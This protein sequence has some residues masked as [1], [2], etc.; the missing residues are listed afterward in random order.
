MAGG[1]NGSRAGHNVRTNGT[2]RRKA[3]SLLAA[4]TA[5]ASNL[6]PIRA[7]T[8][9]WDSNTGTAG[10]Q[11]GGGNW[12]V[13]STTFWNGTTNV[14]TLNDLTSDIAR[15]GNGGTLTA[16]DN[17][18]VGTQS[19]NG[20]VFDTTQS[21]G[22]TLLGTTSGQ[23]LS[24]GSGGITVNSGALATTVGNAT[25]LDLNLGA[26]QTWTNNSTAGG[27]TLTVASAVRGLN[28]NLTLTGSANT[29]VSGVIS[30]GGNLIKDGAGTLTLVANNTYAGT[31]TISAG[32]LAINGGSILPVRSAV[33]VASGATFDYRDTAT[34]IGSLS[35]AGTVTNSTATAGRTLTIGRDDTSTTF[36]GQFLG[37]ATKSRLAI[38]KIGAGT[39]TLAPQSGSSGTAAG[40]YT[41]A[42]VLNGGALELDFSQG[43]FTGTSMLAATAPTIAGGNLLVKGRSGESINQTLGNLTIGAGGGSV[44]IN[45]NAGTATRLNFGTITS[46][47][48]GGSLLVNSPS[49]ADVR[50]NQALNTAINGRIVFTD[51]TGT[52]NWATNAGVNTTTVGLAAYTDVAGGAPTGTDTNNSRIASLI[53]SESTTLGGAWTTNS[54]RINAGAAGQSL[55]LGANTLTLTNGG[56]LF[57]GAENYS[58]TATTGTLKSNTATNSDLV[59]HNYGS[60]NLTIGAIIAN[61]AGASTLTTAGT[62]VVTLTGVNTF[63]GAVFVGGNS[64]LSFSNNNQLGAATASTAINIRDGATL[65]YTGATA[66][67]S[68]TGAASHSFV[69]QGGNANFEVVSGVTLTLNGVI[70]GAGGFTK[71]G[72]GGL[73]LTPLDGAGAATSHTYTGPTF[74]S[75]GTLTVGGGDRL[76]DSSPV[77]VASLATYNMSAGSDT[78]GS[79]AGAGIVSAGTTART[80]TMGG[81]NTSTTFTGTLT[82]A[83]GHA[84]TKT[85]AGTMTVGLGAVTTWTGNTNVNA[86]ILRLTNANVPT[87][88]TMVIGNSAAPAQLDLNGQSPTLSALTFL[89]T[90]S[91]PSSEA[92]IVG[93]SGTVTLNGTVTY[94]AIGSGGITALRPAT[95]SGSGSLAMTAARTFDIR[96]S[97]VVLP[98]EAELT[99]GSGLSGAGGGITKTGGGNLRITGTN[100]MSGTTTNTFNSGVTW[101]DYSINNTAKI[102]PAANLAL[103]GGTLTLVGNSSNATS[104]SVA[105]LALSTG[106]SMIGLDSGTGQELLL[107]LG[108]AITRTASQGL[109]RFNLP[110]GTQAGT[111]GFVTSQ[112][113]AATGI[114]GGF[115]TVTDAS[116]ITGFAT[117]SGT[118]I[119]GLASTAQDNVA[120]WTTGIHATDN[121]G[122]TGTTDFE[123]SV[124]SLRFNASAGASTV[125]VQPG[126]LLRVESG[127][128]LQTANVTGGVSV[129]SG[130][131]LASA[132]GNELMFTTDSAS[133]RLEV[134]STI[135]GATTI[136]KGGT[137]TL[138]INSSSNSFTGAVNVFSG[139]LQVS[140]GN[141]IGDT[142][143]LNLSAN[144]GN[145]FEVLADETVGAL[146]SMTT[147]T[148]SGFTVEIRLTSGTLTLNQA[149]VT[150]RTFS[151]LITGAGGFV[152]NGNSGGHNLLLNSAQSSA[153]TGS[154]TVN[155]GLFYVESAGTLGN[156]S[157]LRL[158]KGASFLIS[159]NSTTSSNARILDTT[160][161][162]LNSADG[163]W[164]TETRPSGL[165]IRRDQGS[166]LS[167]TIGVLSAESGASYARLEATVA[168]AI[169]KIQALN[170]TRANNATFAVRGTN[171]SA[172][173]NQR[174]G[175]VITD[176]TNQTAF[177]ASMVGGGSTTLGTK[178]ISIIPWMIAEETT[179]GVGDANMGNTLATYASGQSVRGLNLTTEYNTFASKATNQDNIRESLAANLT[180]VVGQTINSLVINNSS[181]T[182]LSLNVTGTGS[183]QT[184]ALTS[185]TMLFTSTAAVT[186]T[187][188]MA[189]DLGGFDAGIS[190]GGSEYVIFVQN[191]TSAAASGLLTATL[192]SPL[193]STADLTKAG[194]GSLVLTAGGAAGGGSRKTTINEGALQIDALDKIGGNTGDL[195][196]AGGTLR[197]GGVFD[198]STRT[199]RFLQAGGTFDTQTNNIELANPIGDSTSGT[200]TK[201]GSGTLTFSAAATYTGGTIISAGRVALNGGVNGMGTG[202]TSLS[203]AT[204]V[205]Q[206]GGGAGAASQTVTS[207]TGIAGSSIVG[208][209]AGVSTLTVNQSSSTSYLGLIGGAGA[210]E[211]NVAVVKSGN[212]VLALGAVANTFTGG[213][214]VKAG[215]VVGGNNANTFGGNTNVITIGDTS[216]TADASVVFINSQSYAQPITVASGSSGAAT[217]V[218]GT[219][220]GNP[221][222]TGPISLNK[223]LVLAKD[224]TTG[225]FTIAGGIGGSGN[226]FISNNATTGTVVLSTTAIN[227]AGSITNGG[228]ASGTTTISADIGANVNG[229]T[230]K[231]GTSAL[232]LSAANIAFN[233]PITVS[234][235]TLNITGAGT[236]APTVTGLTVAG[237]ATLNTINTKGQTVNLGAGTLNLGAGAGTATFGL[238]LGSLSEYDSYVTSGTATTA[239]VV[240][241]NLTTISGFG[242]GTYTLFQA[243]GGLS[244]ATYTFTASGLPSGLSYSLNTSATQVQFA[245]T[246]FVSGSSL[247]WRGAVNNSWA[248]LNGSLESNF[249]TDAAGTTNAMGLPSAGQSV[250]F[251][252]TGVSGTS[253]TTTLDSAVSIRDLTFNN[254][255]G[256][257]PLGTITVAAGS[258]GTLTLTPTASTAGIVVETGAPAA[259]NI[260]APVTLG[261]SQTWT[262]ADATTVLSVSGGIGG[263][264]G[265]SLT[266]AGSGILALTGTNNYTGSTTVAGGVLRAGAANTLAAG[267]AHVVNSTGT[268]RLNGFANTIP[269]LA[270]TSGGIV[271]NSSGT[272]AILTVSGSASTTFAGTVQN[273][274]GAGTLELRKA[275]GHLTLSGTNTFTGQL[276]VTSVGGEAGR[277]TISGATGTTTTPFVIGSLAGGRGILNIAS[278]A[279]VN[280]SD[281]DMGTNTSAGATYLSGGSL[282]LAAGDATDVFTLG[283]VANSYGYF[284]QSGGTLVANRITIGGNAGTSTGVY[285]MTGG[286]ATI[287]NWVIVAHGVNSNGLLD[288]AGGTLTWNGASGFATSVGDVA[289]QTGVINIRGGGEV[290]AAGTTQAIRIFRGNNA[291]S[292]NS[293]NILNLMSGG[294]LRT[295]SQGITNGTASGAT[296]N[297][298][299]INLNGGTIV[300]N[301]ATTGLINVNNTNS[302]LTSTSGAFM[303]SGGLTVDTNSFN[304]TLPASLLAPSGVGV[305]SIAV[306]TAGEG[307]V[308]APMVKISGG[309]GVGATAVANMIDDGL[310][311]GTLK[312]GSITITNPGTGYLATDVLT[313][314]LA[315]NAQTY[316]TQATIGTVTMGSSTL[317]SGGLTK[318]G[319]GTLTLSSA[320]SSFNGPV[321]INGGA[322]SAATFGNIGSNGPLGTGV[323]TNDATN[324][325]SIVLAGGTLS[326]AGTAATATDRLFTVAPAGGQIDS[327]SGTAAN[328]VTFGNTGAIVYSG[329]GARTLT[330]GGANTGANTFTPVINDVS[331]T[332]A[333]SVNKAGAGTW[334]LVGS[335]GYTGGTNIGGGVLIQNGGNTLGPSG[336]ITFTA[337]STLRWATGV[338]NDLSGRLVLAN[339][340]TGTID[341]NGNNVVFAT[342][343]GTTGGTTGVL[344]KAGAGNLTLNAAATHTGG[345]TLTTGGLNIGHAGA[346]GIGTLTLATAG[347]TLDNTSG[348]PLTIST[349]PAQAW[350]N[351]FTFVGTNDLNLGTGAVTLSAARTVT[352]NSNSLTV[353]GVIDGLFAVNKA[354][355]GTLYL[356][357]VNT[358]GAAAGSAL[359]ISGGVLKVDDEAGL[360]NALNDITFSAAGTLQVTNGFNANAGKVITVTGAPGTIQVDAGTLTINSNIVGSNAAGGG[361]IKTGAGTLALTAA[362]T[363]YDAQGVGVNTATG[364]GFRVDAGTLLLQSSSNSVVGDNN[365]NNMTVQLNGGHLGIQTDVVSIARANVWVS[366]PATITVNNDSAGPGILQAIG[367]TGGSQ[368][369][370]GAGSST[371]AIVGGSNVTSGTAI[372]QFANATFVVAPTITITNPAAATMQLSLGAVSAAGNTATFEGNGNLVQS[373]AWS[374]TGGAGI[375]FGTSFTGVATLSQANTYPGV[376]TV[377]GG[378]LRFAASNNLGDASLTNTVTLGGGTLQYTASGTTDLTT[379]R[380]VS[381]TTGTTSTIEVT[382]STGILQASGGIVPSGVGAANLNKTGLGT[383]QVTGAINLN[384]GNLTVSGGTLQAGLAASG[385]GAVSVAGGA[386]LNLFDGAANTATISSLSLSSGSS[387]GF[388]LGAPG[389]PNPTVDIGT[390]DR[391][392]VSN[393]PTTTSPVSLNFNN[394]GGLGVGIYDLINVNSGTLTASHFVLGS[395][396]SGLNYT[397]TAENS[398]QTLRL[399]TT[400]LTFVH[401]QGD[402]DGSWSTGI[403]PPPVTATNWASD[404]AGTTDNLA[405][406]GSN[407]TVVFSTSNAVLT[408]GSLTTTLDGNFNIDSLQFVALPT[409][410]A[411]T[412]VTSVTV[413]QGTSGILTVAPSSSNNGILVGADAGA[414][415]IN[416][417]LVAGVNQ[418]W[419]VSGTGASLTIGDVTYTGSVTKT[420]P[421]VLTLAGPGSGTGGFTLA[422]GTLNVGSATALGTGS[423]TIE[424]GTTIANS[425]ASALT[426]TTNNAQTWNGS[427]TFGGT[428]N[429]SLGTGAVTLAQSTT[430]TTSTA[431]LTIGGAISDGGA[432]RSLTKA[433]TGTLTVGGNA[434]IGGNLAV[435]GGTATF[436]GA[437]NNVG[438]SVTASGTAF[439]MNGNTTVGNGISVTAGTANMAGANNVTGSVVVTGGSLVFGSAANAGT[440]SAGV[441]VTGGSLTL[442]GSNVVGTGVTVNGGGTLNIGHA[443][444]LGNNIANT[445]TINGGTIDNTSGAALTLSPANRAHNWNG[446]FTFTGT[447]DLNLGTG[448]VDLGTSVTITTTTAGKSLTVGGVIDDG[449]GTLN[450]TKS[451]AGTLVLN[452]LN[453]YGG[454]TVLDNGTLNINS[455]VSLAGGVTFGSANTVTTAATLNLP[456]GATF[457]GPLIVQATTSGES[458]IALGA[459]QTLTMTTSA[460]SNI[461]NGGSAGSATSGGRLK[462]TGATSSLV[463]NAPGRVFRVG[464]SSTAVGSNYLDLSELG[465]LNMDLGSAGAFRFGS[466]ETANNPADTNVVKLA[467]NSTVKTGTLDI[468]G[469][470]SHTGTA[471][472][473]L[474]TGTTT[475]NANTI[476]I[477]SRASGNEARRASGTLNFAHATNGNVII[478]GYDGVAAA[479]INLVNSNANTGT[480]ISANLSLA[481]HNADVLFSTLTAASRTPAATTTTQN[482]SASITF[483]QGLFT[484]TG[485]T[486]LSNRGGASYT[487]GDTIASASFGGGSTSFATLTM[488][489]NSASTANSSGAAVSTLTFNGNGV[490]TIA[491]LNMGTSTVSGASAIDDP[492]FL[493]TTRATLD[494]SGTASLTITTL[495]MSVNSATS[496]VTGATSTKADVNISGGSVNVTGNVSMGNTTANPLNVVNNAITL[497][498]GTFTV[499]GNIA[500]TNGVG[501]ENA[502]ITLNNGTLDMTAGTIGAA[503]PATIVFNAQ[504]GTLQNLAQLNGGGTLTKSTAGT[505]ILTGTNAYTGVTD[506]TAGV[507]RVQSVSGLGATAGATSITAG[508]NLQI[509]NVDIGAENLTLNGTG[510][511]SGGALTGTGTLAAVGGGVTLAS[512][513][514]VGVALASDTLTLSGVID[515]TGG[516]RMLTKV[517]AGRL[518]LSGSSANTFTGDLNIMAG[519]V[520]LNKTAGVIAIAGD[521]VDSKSNPDVLINGGTLRLL[522]DNQIGDNVYIN[523]TSGTFSLNGKNETIFFFNN[524]GGAFNSGRGG[525]LTVTD[526][527]WS[528]GTNHV[529]NTQNYGLTVPG[530]TIEVA[531]DISGGLNMVHGAESFASGGVINVGSDFAIIQFSGATPNLTLNGDKVIP[532]RLSL[533]GNVNVTAGTQ[534]TITSGQALLPDMNL[535]DGVDITP[536][537]DQTGVLAGKVD[538][539]TGNRT[540]TVG[541]G[542]SLAISAVVQGSGGGLVKAGPGLMTLSAINTYTGPTTITAGTLVVT[543][544]ISSATEAVTNGTLAGNGAVTEAVMVNAGGTIRPGVPGGPATGVLTVKSL[545][546]A[547]NTSAVYGVDITGASPGSGYDQIALPNAGTSTVSIDGA[548]LSV[549]LGTLLAGDG[550]EKFYIINNASPTAGTVTG[551]FANLIVE[552]SPA[553]G[554]PSTTTLTSATPNGS[555]GF[556]FTDLSTGFVYTLVYNVD[557]LT[558]NLTPGSG[559]DVVLSVVPE[560]GSLALAA[561]AGLGL[562]ARRRRK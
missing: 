113:N 68:Q 537:P 133:Q 313:V 42:T 517:G 34:T 279:T 448:A 184:L 5:I 289:G 112:A 388:D 58:I 429:L 326:Y 98:T 339:G 152:V 514:S 505:L 222:L 258:G 421:G 464:G 123:T 38:T 274:T 556:A 234:G 396:P 224:G 54:L 150:G 262:V 369:T 82:G 267:S 482:G 540:F 159:N 409:S 167:E 209:N 67:I 385:V 321:T 105:N 445:F 142:A 332:E 32:T 69:L 299:L 95:I 424:A 473:T 35:G 249:T 94:N 154:V 404:A 124:N 76:P 74:I 474:N 426:L 550:S 103:G 533:F 245:A 285:R 379:N 127:G 204:S 149:S 215:T 238:E 524:S 449:V 158:N 44:I 186:G 52:F 20:L 147:S 173:A 323:A 506:V 287:N 2:R 450:L 401:W 343:V 479:A 374:G 90:G 77:T 31:T 164:N 377:N 143:A 453:T 538:L 317:A 228:L 50:F 121:S 460:D 433:G 203:G 423:L 37:P 496:A 9:D 425:T 413:N 308:G 111:N 125:T 508:A 478:R 359:T 510:I 212:G 161:I 300:T 169:T 6:S 497:T 243:A 452:A 380:P 1:S 364:V 489:Q 56:L 461:G 277:V 428:Q 315:N 271:E 26:N 45:N 408:S 291:N 17:V 439:T 329:A 156:V 296:G 260:S 70:S 181:A 362:S 239:N 319:A 303:Y 7:A 432:G 430:V 19:I 523:M 411:P 294:T 541:T 484:V 389:T 354:G 213:L 120:L 555:G 515:E 252:A 24:L 221:T 552:A 531:H 337:N 141:A 73:T 283:Q 49:G 522:A 250:V 207:L 155:G 358:F 118:N 86:G 197:F 447:N 435:T 109:V 363:A 278:G 487:T 509:E 371:L 229:I 175:L 81:D 334:S 544:L 499:G 341:T 437:T 367:G 438:G 137:G 83:A 353:G 129:I 387:L 190:A 419:D 403:S 160:G 311:L 11:D 422:A 211:N 459:G 336:N 477:G 511:S 248:A 391:L 290:I 302:V 370:M 99:V 256:A 331:G 43:T 226:L 559:N 273:G 360:G 102:N 490:N 89:G 376:T 244:D 393:A 528:G 316:T 237:G 382:S 518:V 340:V 139:T 15:F 412:P 247:Y 356:S 457:G 483:D 351:N 254:T 10:A 501:T 350:N 92:S 519:T 553:Y 201:T 527:I 434:T 557:S 441:S 55:V 560:P 349:N 14:A 536:D 116:G 85:G 361:L 462:I 347:V 414:V 182:A 399:T 233:G 146:S 178:T 440:I 265:N 59:I 476:D 27:T 208:G 520:E 126:G 346:L 529:F 532:G 30:I 193:T 242:A 84:F 525:G 498:S 107:N 297:L 119:V 418:T 410:P 495:N 227:H 205:L 174:A 281:L 194:R 467:V 420:G 144:Q 365:P 183:G 558:N 138:R 264:G 530:P 100:T 386:T 246:A 406:P 80:L 493:G 504:A 372:A 542:G 512:D 288:I 36:S 272:G 40:D 189:I 330:F 492:T 8:L 345:V 471:T 53:V 301:A 153:W 384:G 551:Q 47:A 231:S 199:V 18:L 29:T 65:R 61:G 312:I 66:T 218:G 151:G 443:E 171:L 108:T 516:A 304:S 526:P 327:T 97:T 240:Q 275:G 282:T 320:T 390:S 305:S 128:I 177:I 463:F 465:T 306:A 280:V 104:Q 172:T 383:L 298:M 481:G 475:V 322:I 214:T 513:S 115:A 392:T 561:M 157:A 451:G 165:A 3:L 436:S 500:Y 195:V 309:T 446:S 48:A 25:F 206:L 307:Y 488:S 335:N 431:T 170:I 486:T 46:T 378:T 219:T 286:V 106:S 398:G 145:V 255:V 185:G 318:N 71:L 134:A 87:T 263:T 180:G 188:A 539:N 269:S 458:V 191:P 328:T 21:L 110:T 63:T 60:G 444:A 543:G 355:A 503:S 455:A 348:G 407:A 314:T 470:V 216:G 253:L 381:L 494:V 101:L 117:K 333:V 366:A 534:A 202:G 176:A 373:A 88:G 397:F 338:T 261:A 23:V 166:T 96:N 62:G 466:S 132:T 78:I 442:A 259:I 198:P 64:T 225:V 293:T 12:T 192:S 51:D 91:T 416:A 270:G 454:T 375:T 196:L 415:T 485:T 79:L 168:S 562:L 41:G 456:S 480:A 342:A 236:T 292:D 402:I 554:V 28:S 352:V 230:Q 131:T 368:L 162:T 235:G 295:N 268:L 344:N 179:S 310:G 394:L 16:V 324:A 502:T 472:L 284:E 223:D 148:A 521:G 22:Y 257:G 546:M 187:P 491:T 122:Y 136:T 57:T 535:D 39:L 217:I 130:G 75:A 325:A 93:L 400:N 220:T 468:A 266:K 395:A 548:S 13:G 232:T 276:L 210:N 545:A 405:G 357:G 4:A 200:L 33:S 251:S 469:T 547:N 72:A 163:A 114:L 507:V 427:F 241:L 417:P 549:K 140:G 135:S